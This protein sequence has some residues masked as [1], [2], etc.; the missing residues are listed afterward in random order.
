[1]SRELAAALAQ[2]ESLRSTVAALQVQNAVLSDTVRGLESQVKM[3]SRNSLMPQPHTV[4]RPSSD[5]PGIDREAQSGRGHRRKRPRGG[6][7]GHA[8]TAR[9][10]IGPDD[11]DR[12]EDVIPAP[13]DQCGEPLTGCD[14]AP[15]GRPLYETS[16]LTIQ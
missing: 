1:M 12:R 13:F 16:A 2:V 9:P 7:P 15:L 4:G 5:R 3:N 8:S 14:D 6:Q 11:A 10:P